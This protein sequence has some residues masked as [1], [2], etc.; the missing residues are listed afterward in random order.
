MSGL[1]LSLRCNRM[2]RSTAWKVTHVDAQ[3]RRRRTVLRAADNR[4]VSA[5]AEAMYGEA[6]ALSVVRMDRLTRLRAQWGEA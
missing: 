1:D 2:R 6:L 3:G 4:T 5:I